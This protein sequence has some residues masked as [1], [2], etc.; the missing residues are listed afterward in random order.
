MRRGWSDEDIKKL[1][2]QNV[3]RVLRAGRRGVAQ[4]AQDRPASDALIEELD[5]K[6]A[7]KAATAE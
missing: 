6:P 2:G 4:A 3:L 7:V 5:G 1:A